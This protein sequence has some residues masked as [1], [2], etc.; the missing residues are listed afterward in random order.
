MDP[1]ANLREQRELAAGVLSSIRAIDE[2]GAD[3][4]E[5]DSLAER[6][7][8]LAELVQALDE[9]RLR[10]GFDP[11]SGEP[12]G[13]GLQWAV[14]LDAVVVEGSDAERYECRAAED[15]DE[16]SWGRLA[17]AIREADVDGEWIFAEPRKATLLASALK[18][19]SPD[20][21]VTIVV[22]HEE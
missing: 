12:D 8:R 17:N 2:Q 20:D 16:P 5:R 10:G 21:L 22:W 6:A 7:E 19:A 1:L 13:N 14:H 18:H 3:F 9:W 15:A 4:D 11:Y